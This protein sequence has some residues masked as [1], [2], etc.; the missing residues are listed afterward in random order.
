LEGVSSIY[1]LG[2]L[3]GLPLSLVDAEGVILIQ[4]LPH[5]KPFGSIFFYY[6]ANVHWVSV[7]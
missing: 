3:N 4:L 5:A 7:H 2:G 1:R 6:R